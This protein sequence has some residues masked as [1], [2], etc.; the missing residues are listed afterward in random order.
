MDAMLEQ[1]ARLLGSDATSVRELSAAAWLLSLTDGR[2]V[3]I[4]R[5]PRQEARDW[6]PGRPWTE[7][8]AIDFLSSEGLSVPKLLAADLNHGWLIREYVEGRPLHLLVDEP[9]FAVYRALVHHLEHIEQVLQAHRHE[10][11]GIRWWDLQRGSDPLWWAQRLES[12]LSP[13]VRGA[14][15]DLAVEAAAGAIQL[16]PLDVQAANALWD[17]EKT[18]LI[19]WATVGQDYRERRLVAYAQAAFP[20]PVTLLDEAA[21]QRHAREFGASAARC[22]AFWDLAFW[23]T[24][25]VRAQ[26]GQ[27][28]SEANVQTIAAMWRRH[29]LNDA[30]IAAVQS[31]L[32]L[33][34]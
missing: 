8:V 20:T 13:Q 19:D 11:G 6:R 28:Y 27:T 24:A 2:R 4:K 26:S 33:E 30:R 22:L 18:W 23:G 9:T 12:R 21:Y 31:G 29:R 7:L 34:P 1:M 15:R 14:W 32:M 3:V 5:V 10:L 16:G 17:G 25:W